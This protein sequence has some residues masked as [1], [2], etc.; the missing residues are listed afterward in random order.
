MYISV[1]V[2]ALAGI[3]NSASAE[4]SRRLNNGVG[5]TPAMGFNNWNSGLRMLSLPSHERRVLT[6]S[7]HRQQPLH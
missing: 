2:L 3:T 1:T 5:V 4:L 7:Q 6:T